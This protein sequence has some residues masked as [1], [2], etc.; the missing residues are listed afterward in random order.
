VFFVYIFKVEVRLKNRFSGDVKV[1]EAIKSSVH[2]LISNTCPILRSGPIDFGIVSL[3]VENVEAIII[4]DLDEVIPNT[5]EIPLWQSILDIYMYTCE[6]E[7]ATEDS[8]GGDDETPS[9]T[10]WMLP[11][12]SLEGTW[13]SLIYEPGLKKR[14]ISYV[15]TSLLFSH[16][17]VDIN[18]VACNR[19][20]LL[21]GPPGTGKTSL[22]RC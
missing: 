18:I 13:E 14:L 10:Q 8:E 16:R 19:L 2:N 15:Y 4:C 5:L 22:C 7:G 9:C 12:K 21:H 1:V 6:E 20:I 11:N 17:N 3:L